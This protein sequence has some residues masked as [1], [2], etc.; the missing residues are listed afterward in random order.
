[1]SRK[2]PRPASS[3]ALLAGFAI[4]RDRDSKST[5]SRG[6]Q[7]RMALRV[8]ERKKPISLSIKNYMKPPSLNRT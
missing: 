2:K 7:Q 1:V 4:Q 6:T 8:T 3:G 5:V